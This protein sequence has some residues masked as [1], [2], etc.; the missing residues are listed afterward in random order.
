[1]NNDGE[2]DYS[3]YSYRELLEALDSISSRKYPKN[4]ANLQAALEKVG[5]AQREALAQESA[6]DPL[7]EDESYDYESQSDP[8]LRRINHLVT[9][10]FYSRWLFP[11][12]SYSIMLIIET[13]ERNI[14]FSLCSRSRSLLS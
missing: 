1:M 6:S 9:W 8:D 10:P 5:P 14:Y 2:I 12:L 4:Y 13:I 7:S 11:H 3:R